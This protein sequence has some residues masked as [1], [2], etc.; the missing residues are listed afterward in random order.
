[1]KKIFKKTVKILIDLVLMLCMLVGAQQTMNLPIGWAC[2]GYMVMFASGLTAWTLFNSN[3]EQPSNQSY[4][5]SCFIMKLSDALILVDKNY[6]FEYIDFK[7]DGKKS[8]LCPF[9]FEEDGLLSEVRELIDKE[10]EKKEE[11]NEEE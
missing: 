10:E 2:I 6:V 4:K 7:R 11:V 8:I 5:N 1:M 9:T 3:Y